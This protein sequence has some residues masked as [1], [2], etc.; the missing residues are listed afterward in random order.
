MK[1]RVTWDTNG[2]SNEELGLPEVDMPIMNED[3]IADYL[4]HANRHHRFGQRLL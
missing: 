2:M 3:E 1:V 4:Y